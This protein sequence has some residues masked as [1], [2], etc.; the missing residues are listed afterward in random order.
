MKKFCRFLLRIDAGPLKGSKA[1]FHEC[2]EECGHL[3]SREEYS[4]ATPVSGLLMN[5]RI[6]RMICSIAH[7]SGVASTFSQFKVPLERPTKA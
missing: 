7:I 2:G 3:H 5:T 1:I 4:S 6:L